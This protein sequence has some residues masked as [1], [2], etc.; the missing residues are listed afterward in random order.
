[1]EPVVRRA[2]CELIREAIAVAQQE[3]LQAVERVSRFYDAAKSEHAILTAMSDGIERDSARRFSALEGAL[4]AQ[5]QRLGGV[6]EIVEGQESMSAQAQA[7]A[8]EVRQ[9]L[10]RLQAISTE[11]VLLAVNAKVQAAHLGQQMQAVQVIATAMRDLAKGLDDCSTDLEDT[12]SKLEASIPVLADQSEMLRRTSSASKNAMSSL[13]NEITETQREQ[14]L[15]VNKLM[16]D[17]ITR[18]AQNTQEVH[19]LLA[20]LQFVDRISQLL[21]AALIRL[22]PDEASANIGIPDSLLTADSPDDGTDIGDDLV[23]L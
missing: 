9:V 21:N 12:Q 6:A 20:S 10:K 2:A 16:S 17:C 3:T 23:F 8:T 1:M 22:D 19:A 15:Y 4:Q 11:S 13:E 14:D 7:A 18:A 5:S